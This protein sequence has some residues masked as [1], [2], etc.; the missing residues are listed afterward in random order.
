MRRV[1]VRSLPSGQPQ[2]SESARRTPPRPP[3]TAI[4]AELLPLLPVTIR[5]QGRVVGR[6]ALEVVDR[7]AHPVAATVELISEWEDGLIVHLA[8]GEG[9]ATLRAQIEI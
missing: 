2:P 9:S 8:L 5:Y 3:R 4:G 1:T 7:E 6:S